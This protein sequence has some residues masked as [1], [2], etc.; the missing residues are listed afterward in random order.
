[1]IAAIVAAQQ[2]DG[3]GIGGP[4]GRRHRGFDGPGAR[5]GFGLDEVAT[6]LGITADDVRTALEGGQS[7]A[8]LAV[9][10]GKTAQDVIDAIVAEATTKLDAAVTDGKLTQ[11]QADARLA[12]LTT[13][14]TEFVNNTPPSAGPVS[15][16]VSVVRSRFRRSRPPRS[17]QRCR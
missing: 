6:T 3:P 7:I 9:S 15:A 14:A 10:K 1:M 12:D 17:R 2:V 11:A 13:R 5:I 16:P 8:D 4:M